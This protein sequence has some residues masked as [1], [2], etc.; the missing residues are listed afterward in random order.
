M[1]GCAS[2]GGGKGG[3]GKRDES[4][5]KPRKGAEPGLDISPSEYQKSL[6]RRLSAEG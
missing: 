5:K 1:G 6:K 2:R 3:G 4:S